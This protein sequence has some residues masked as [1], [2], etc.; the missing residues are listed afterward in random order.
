MRLVYPA[1]MRSRAVAVVIRAGHLLV[2]GRRKNG[3]VYAVL[4]GGGVESDESA[5]Q[6]CLR[7]LLEETGLHGDGPAA[8]TVPA[9]PG[10]IA[11]Y[12]SVTVTQDEL[13]LG[14]PERER[15][16]ADDVYQPR[17]VPLDAIE[18]I[19]LVPAEAVLAI[20]AALLRQ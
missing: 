5:E 4:P 12:F 11:H 3:R 2:I 7:E 15:A 9:Q 18:D 19:G 6:A 10:S 16:G 17:W 8:L 20:S 14:G 1:R 13:R